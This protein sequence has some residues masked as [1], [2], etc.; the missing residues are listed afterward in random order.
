MGPRGGGR[1]GFNRGPQ[2]PRGLATAVGGG[3][4]GGG[5]GRGGF[6]GRGGGGGGRGRGG[7]GGGGGGRPASRKEL[8]KAARQERKHHRFEAQQ[9]HATARHAAAQGGAG[10]KRPAQQQDGGAGGGEPAA[11]RQRAEQPPLAQQGAP[12]AARAPRPQPQRAPQPAAGGGGAAA[13]GSS[14]T[15]FYDML[16]AEGVAPAPGGGAA[17]A[18]SQAAF[19]ADLA[20]Q[21]EMARKLKVKKGSQRS[22]PE[23]GLDAL[24]A[25]ITA[26]TSHLPAG[27]DGAAQPS[28]G[29][30][31]SGS[32][33]SGSDASGS[34]SEGGWGEGESSDGGLSSDNEGAD[35]LSGGSSDGGGG[36][37]FDLDGSEGEQEEG[38][39]GEGESEEDD[40]LMGMLGGA[41]SDEL[42]A[43]GSGDDEGGSGSG[44][45][46]GG[47]GSLEESDGDGEP[48]QRPA[49]G[50]KAAALAPEAAA[51]G[52][53][54]YV[55]PALRRAQE[56]A[57]AAGGGGLAPAVQRRV[58]GLLNRLA[59]SNL[60]GI[61]AELLVLYQ[62]EGR[63]WVGDAVSAGLLAAVAEGPRA[64]EQFAAVA[65]V[66]VGG[67]AAGARAQDVSARFLEMLAAR[68]EQVCCAALCAAPAAL[69]RR[70]PRRP[71]SA[72][73][74]RTAPAAPRRASKAY[75]AGDGLA[76]HNLVMLLAY[77]FS[78]GV[79]AADLV[80]SVLG[81]LTRRFEEG[82]VAM[83]LTLL[84]AVG[85][86][87]RATDP[88]AMKGFVLAVHARAAAAGGRM[89]KRAEIMLELVMD[90]KNNRAREA[91]AK[92]KKG[93]AAGGGGGGG[94]AAAG[95][96]GA[97]A[98]L[99]PP[100][101]KWLRGAGVADVT[102]ANVSWAKL[103][104][105]DKKGMW[106]HPSA[107]D[108]A[109]GLL[110][111]VLAE[112][113]AAGA[114]AAAA[115]AAAADADDDDDG[116]GAGA[117]AGAGGGA[118]GAA[119][120]LALA[121]GMRMT[122][123]ARR[124]VFVAVMGSEDCAEAAEKLLR[125]PLKGD[126]SREV[127]R[128]LV[129]CALQEARYNPYYGHLAARL[130]AV[131]KAHKA[132][133]GAARRGAP[134]GARGPQ[135]RGRARGRGLG[136]LGARRLTAAAGCPGAACVPCQVTLQYCLWDQWKEVGATE[137]RRLLCL[138][139]LV[140]HVLAAFTLP[141][142]ALKPIDF[143]AC[144]SWTAKETFLWRHTLQAALSGFRAD[145][146][147]EAAFGRLASQ[148]PLGGLSRGLGLFLRLRVGPWLV[149]QGDAGLLARP[150]ADACLRRLAA[151]EKTLL[152]S[153]AAVLAGPHP[154]RRP[155]APATT[156]AP[157]PPPRTPRAAPELIVKASAVL[158]LSKL[159]RVACACAPGGGGGA[160]FYSNQILARK[161]PLGLVWIAA[162]LDRQLRR[163]QINDTSIP[164][165]V[166]TLLDT[167]V[168]LALRLSGQLLLG[169]VRIYARKVGY[170]AE[171]CESALGKIQ[172]ALH[173]ADSATLAPGA[174]C[175]PMAAIT[176]L[177]ARGRRKAPRRGAGAECAAEDDAAALGDD[178]GLL[179][180]DAFA[181]EQDVLLA[182][183]AGFGAWE[184]AGAGGG[185]A[186]DLGGAA[187]SASG[188][189]SADVSSLWGMASSGAGDAE[190]FDAA[191]E[192]AA[193]VWDLDAVEV[194]RLRA[195]PPSAATGA[196]G[197]GVSGLLGLAPPLDGTPGVDGPR[198]KTAARTPADSEGDDAL[199][200]PPPDLDDPLPASPRG[201]VPALGDGRGAD[202]TPMSRFAP[203]GASPGADVLPPTPGGS[204]GGYAG[205]PTPG[206][207]GD[208]AAVLPPTP[209]ADDAMECDA[210]PAGADAADQLQADQG[211]ARGVAK[212]FQRR[213]AARG[214]AAPEPEAPPAPTAA[215]A[216]A[217][218]QRR[219]GAVLGQK[220]RMQLDDAPPAGG[221]AGEHGAGGRRQPPTELPARRFRALIADWGELLDPAR[222]EL[223]GR[224]GQ[225]AAAGARQ[226]L[227]AHAGAR[228][229][230]V[231]GT[232]GAAGVL[233]APAL[234]LPPQL[235]ALFAG[236]AAGR[237]AGGAGADAGGAA[238]AAALD[239]IGLLGPDDDGEL[240]APGAFLAS[241]GLGLLG[242]PG[243][244]GGGDA[245]PA[246]RG[247]GG[248][249]G[250]PPPS[251]GPAGYTGGS[252]PDCAGGF[253]PGLTPGGL[254]DEAGALRLLSPQAH[255]PGSARG[256]VLQLA[257]QAHDDDGGAGG[258]QGLWGKE[259]LAPG[260]T[261]HSS[262]VSTQEPLP[263]A[264]D[265]ETLV[266]LPPDGAEAPADGGFTA[267]TRLVMRQLQRAGAAAAGRAGGAA[268]A[269]AATPSG[270]GRKRVS[271]APPPAL[272]KGGA[273][274][275][276]T[277]SFAA[278]TAGHG[279]L[280]ACRWFYETLV[281]ANRGL[282][283]R[284]SSFLTEQQRAALDAALAERFAAGG[285]T[286]GKGAH[287]A[288]SSGPHAG[289]KKSKSVKGSGATKKGGGGGKF[290]WG[291]LL[292]GEEG[293]SALD[294]HDPNYDSDEER[295]AVILAAANPARSR[296]AAEVAAYKQEITA[297]AE[298][299]FASGDVGDAAASLAELGAAEAMGHYFVKR[300]ITLSLDRKD[301]EREMASGLLSSLY[302]EALPGDQ[303][304]KGFARL[305]ES[306]DDLVLDVPNAVELLALFIARGVVDDV[307]P[308][309]CVARWAA[310]APEGSTLAALRA[311]TEQHLA[312][313]HSAERLLRC[314]GS[315][316][317]QTYGETKERIAKL[318]A[319][320]LD[321]RDAAEASRC[322]RGLAVPFFH[323][324]L[325]KQ[326]LHAALEVPA[327]GDA[328]IALLT[329]LSESSEVN[330]SQLAKG[331][332]RTA[333]NLPDTALDNPAAPER[334]DAL[335]AAAA[336]ADLVEPDAV[337][338]LKATAAGPAAG[339]AARPPSSNG[340]APALN[341]DGGGLLGGAG[342]PAFKSAM[343]AALKEFFNS[344]DVQE[345][346]ARLSELG[347]P[348]L[349]P[350]FVKQVVTLAMD[351]RDR[352]REMASSLLSE[353]HPAVITD[354]QMVSGFS[355]LLA[356]CDD[357]ILDI[358]DAVHLLSLF[359]G[360]AIVD[361]VLP[362]A[363]LASC[364]PAL[365]DGGLGITVVQATGAMLSQR[366][367]AE[368]LTA[369]WHGGGLSLDDVR[370][371]M[372]GALDEFLLAGSGAE[373]AAV[374]KDMDLPHYHHE[375][376][377]AAVEM[378]F[379]SP[380][381][382]PQLAG[383][384]RQLSETGVI[385]S[386]QMAQARRP[387]APGRGARARLARRRAR[388]A[389]RARR[390]TAPGP[391]PRAP[392]TRARRR[393]GQGLARVRDLLADE[394]LDAPGAPAAFEKLLAQA[395]AEGWLPQEMASS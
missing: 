66:A 345:V 349:H 110:P 198:G 2:L 99:Q 74:V 246:S 353:L 188:L 278:L 277:L 137:P 28:S 98:V 299:Y 340:A 168:P 104:Q 209:A 131:S 123:D 218:K 381:R 40:G 257:T 311:R 368:R 269:A 52:A 175:A 116:G 155:H 247:A 75:A 190:V 234:A 181:W 117:G 128:V 12:P 162:H 254:E 63:R 385:S 176:L 224:R 171:D 341:G 114:A 124:A 289:D 342:V 92:A 350:L 208:A 77:A 291:R 228:P 68:L 283:A 13:H 50:A 54:K 163:K 303:V 302:A 337:A 285:R 357:L 201:L 309:A 82:D 352:E 250:A 211:D 101:L 351:R 390:C 200:A 152:S 221:E 53:A 108:A 23:D 356:S 268:V 263:W 174:Q 389:R 282:P 10:A 9:A 72:A 364:L 179:G 30:D 375:L 15:K 272:A 270:A 326:A 315:G 47:S 327:H 138:A 273:G 86:Q 36:L 363:F 122:T 348:G 161:G 7:R 194:E 8:R 394:A 244:A 5:R 29:S 215:A 34:G 308:P 373:V 55:P 133:C 17:G 212:T 186:I 172:V 141:L 329:R 245:T 21:R 339:D 317:G 139:G 370:R 1:G 235:Q 165:S 91:K 170:L 382:A 33:A 87:L 260:G 338:E 130:A 292:E 120:L 362:P 261:F 100:L 125:L 185:F 361:E 25:G 4:G 395:G 360:R 310:G 95:R 219:V 249:D 237:R 383:L 240:D 132:R 71:P 140:G 45:G 290:T 276:P 243:S 157:A 178:G 196:S 372:R 265:A 220:R 80:F 136:G 37:G 160:M 105:P 336:A 296:I 379:G 365:P 213:G 354:D 223:V 355:R 321:S 343:A 242:T 19:L 182:R 230:C 88:A 38:E 81:E 284:M 49:V 103:L 335:L 359:L 378:V 146:D 48:R 106:W 314:W 154:P 316:A 111:G 206:S 258:S 115:A 93:A 159:P 376:V 305:V 393:R 69:R 293:V 147:A 129:E 127:M 226:A 43:S 294:R 380:A 251:A 318:L 173:R 347:Q 32:D 225:P 59:E 301:K 262:L 11:K 26:G 3:G 346:A 271:P 180:A 256:L 35:G 192:E 377:K 264:A 46:E 236:A 267:R 135:G 259:N 214:A 16:A 96:G 102:L 20:L 195:A 202:G 18:A 148:A 331:L 199:H 184:A 387:R 197:G 279:R 14:R 76:C 150:A 126:Q 386:T 330:A 324:E 153:T 203:R 217:A 191:D 27:L 233:G 210:P 121:A 144:A 298:E 56:A 60:Q 183:D 207:A 238:P 193:A 229:P 384:L 177:P 118:P 143:D 307:L 227:L 288:P 297:I 322:L 281:L 388:H 295:A 313:R 62:S 65:A 44:D 312:A 158:V 222:A 189:L 286:G 274:A 156:T 231:P 22:G 24:L 64:T 166:D 374:L 306:L 94:A 300:L 323:H 304:Q 169:V 334:F 371:S 41:S 112:H 320:Y 145:A 58:T 328:V 31:A 367:A 241:P 42:D 85:L 167:E 204:A 79:V 255:A 266:E 391:P 187:P 358:P 344:A 325:V 107:T 83:M 89:S 73:R 275:D 109:A 90:I 97:A 142:S 39:S 51:A 67:L 149:A 151:A 216:K 78:A 205:G 248:D 280:D 119:Q 70:A 57:A 332:Q 392:P 113:D 84:N 253:T 366:H 333:A 61:V 6:G 287:H 319:E 164:A 239:E 369:C 232:L 252:L 134:R